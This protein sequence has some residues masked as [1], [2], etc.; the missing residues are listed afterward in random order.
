MSATSDLLATLRRSYINPN[1]QDPGGVFVHEVTA[2]GYW[3][4]D[5]RCDAVYLGF[6]N[7]SGRIM[8]GHELKTSRPDWLRELD[9][10]TKADDWADQCHEF[11]VVVSDPEIVDEKEL[12]RGWGLMS[13][14]SGRSRTRMTRHVPAARK[15]AHNPSW[16]ALRSVL[17]RAEKLRIAAIE[18]GLKDAQRIAQADAHVESE[19]R[20]QRRIAGQRSLDAEQ[21]RERLASVEMALGTPIDWDADEHGVGPHGVSLAGIA[22]IA[23]AIRTHGD[24]ERALAAF[25]GRFSLIKAAREKVDQLEEAI[26]ELQNLALH[27][28]PTTKVAS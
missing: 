9:K 11:W 16:D 18:Q 14:P 8:V 19:K 5:R 28:F 7:A 3:G 2:N 6:T 23:G 20:W 27:E 1:E 17:A 26:T 22:A 4:D 21:L 24:F 25:S 15:T 10:R 12:P 13:P